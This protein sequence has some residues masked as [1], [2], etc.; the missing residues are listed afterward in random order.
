MKFLLLFES[1]QI[2]ETS[3]T[4]LKNQVEY[5]KI[6]AEIPLLK[7]HIFRAHDV[8]RCMGVKVRSYRYQIF[9]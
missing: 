9:L 5:A 4:Y 3:K 8:E 6:Q 2:E 1:Q 7:S